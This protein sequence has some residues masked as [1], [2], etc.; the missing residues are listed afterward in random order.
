MTFSFCGS[1]WREGG[2]GSAERLELAC[3]AARERLRAA[4][5]VRVNDYLKVV[6]AAEQGGAE[7]ALA[8]IG[9]GPRD[10]PLLERVWRRRAAAEPEVARAIAEALGPQRKA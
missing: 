6:L 5:S 3:A 10:L 7:R 4:A 1:I 9:L 2:A 8:E